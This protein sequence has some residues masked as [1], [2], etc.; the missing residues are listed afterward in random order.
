MK[1][2]LQ[3][4]KRKKSLERM[5]GKVESFK[6]SDFQRQVIVEEMSNYK[7]PESNGSMRVEEYKKPG[8]IRNQPL[9]ADPT[10]FQSMINKNNF[11]S[12]KPNLIEHH[13]YVLVPADIWAFFKSWY[14]YDFVL[15]RYIKRDQ[16]NQDKLYLELYPEKKLTDGGTL[17][18]QPPTSQKQLGAIETSFENLGGNSGL[19]SG[20]E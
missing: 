16:M 15:L 17:K 11:I 3:A 9:L 13:D 6:S 10:Y 18:D 20:R 19:S 12:L 1:L 5:K 14:D 8:I 7:F 2:E 4:I